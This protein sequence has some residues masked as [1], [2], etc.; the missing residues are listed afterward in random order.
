MADWEEMLG[1]VLNDPAQMGKITQMAQSLLGGQP[2][3]R[4][5]SA[6]SGL[7]ALLGQSGGDDKQALLTAMRP[8]L[9]QRH[10]DKMDRALKLAKMARLARLAMR[11]SGG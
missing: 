6:P 11:E 7:E 4:E 8:W 9:D 10:R 3:Q 5:D 2:E 1:Q